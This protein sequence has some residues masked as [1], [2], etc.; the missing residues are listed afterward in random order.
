MDN[1]NTQVTVEKNGVVSRVNYAP[2]ALLPL[3]LFAGASHAAVDVSAA[4]TEISG[5]IAPVAA[6]GGAIL[7]VLVAI[8]AWKMIRAAM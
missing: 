5:M 1:Q 7:L 6:I 2:A 3:A 8:K 4:T